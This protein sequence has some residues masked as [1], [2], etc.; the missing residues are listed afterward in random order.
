VSAMAINWFRKRYSVYLGDGLT[1]VVS[2]LEKARDVLLDPK[3]PKHNGRTQKR[4][5]EAVLEGAPGID[6]EDAFEAAAVDAGVLVDE[7]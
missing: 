4:A 3:W 1:H 6:P 7:R 5:I 2:S